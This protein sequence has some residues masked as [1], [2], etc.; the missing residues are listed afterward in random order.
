M[1]KKSGYDQKNFEF[2]NE[3]IIH[4]AQEKT[5]QYHKIWLGFMAED[6]LSS[7]TFHGLKTFSNPPNPFSQFEYYSNGVFVDESNMNHDFNLTEEDLVHYVLNDWLPDE[8][9]VGP[10]REN[11]LADTISQFLK[12]SKMNDNDGSDYFA[13]M[14]LIDNFFQEGFSLK[15]DLDLVYV[16][17]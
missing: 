7:A 6:G 16:Y 9:L 4:V 5:Q 15:Y 3:K 10:R 13:F 2:K 14:D 17:E 11:V 12:E 1:G 8:G